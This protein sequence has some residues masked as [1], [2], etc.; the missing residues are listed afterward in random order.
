MKTYLK[1]QMYLTQKIR[2]SIVKFVYK[3]HFSAE[4]VKN[5]KEIMNSPFKSWHSTALRF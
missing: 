3:L 5:K 1:T 4:I 2:D